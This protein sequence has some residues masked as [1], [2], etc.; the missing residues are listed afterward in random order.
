MSYS[1]DAVMSSVEGGDYGR[2]GHFDYEA[3]G[4]KKGKF[5]S[6]GTGRRDKTER[7]CGDTGTE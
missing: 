7:G 1:W 2:K 4:A 5:D 3:G 6:E